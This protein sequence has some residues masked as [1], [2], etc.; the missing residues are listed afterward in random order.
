[1]RFTKM[2]GIGNDYVYINC[3]E[4]TVDNP[5]ELAVKLSDRNFGIGADGVI[6]IG[7]SQKADFRMDLYNADG[8]FAEMCGNGIRCV[9]KYVYDR[10]L[11][12]KTVITVESGGKIKTLWLEVKDS[13]AHLI[14]VD[15]G[16][17]AL[18]PAEIPVLAEGEAFISKPIR[19][20]DK[21]YSATC[22]NVGNPH[23][24]VFMEDISDFDIERIGPEFERHAMFP[25]R[26]NTEFVQ[27]I[28]RQTL[29]M[30]VWE[31]GSG[32]TK[33]CGTGAC[34]VLVA[35]VLGGLAER[36]ATVILPGGELKIKWDGANGHVY[37]T[38]PA[39]FVFEG[40]L[41]NG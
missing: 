17:P 16:E 25:G 5:S 34:A 18:K 38:G 24:V 39:E 3:F 19:V 6:Y 41:L 35:A 28:D 20:L 14:T 15:M 30:R 23:A 21:E 29:K 22:V 37:M 31:R 9:G 36:E 33:A 27:V 26:T 11:T 1:M 32:E 7:P 12:D 10:G 8:G 13:V 40:T 4:E 2:Q